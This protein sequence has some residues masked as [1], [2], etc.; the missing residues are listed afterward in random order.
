M[1]LLDHLQSIQDP[2][3]ARCRHHH[4]QSIL[5]MALCAT[6][7]G[8]DNWVEVAE[9]GQMH[10]Q[11]FERLIALPSGTPSHDTFARVFRLLDAQQLESAC[12]Q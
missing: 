9:F 6:V 7:A 3:L 11:W 10:R 12:Q 4:L 1:N 8:A 5:V 2:R